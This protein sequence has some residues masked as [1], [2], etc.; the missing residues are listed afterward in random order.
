[1]LG[2]EI[3]ANAKVFEPATENSCIRSFKACRPVSALV[4]APVIAASS[5]AGVEIGMSPDLV[6]LLQE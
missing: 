5:D 6:S 3:F 1:V 4:G 2:R